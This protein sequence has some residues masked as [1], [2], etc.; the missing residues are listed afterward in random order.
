MLDDGRMLS[1]ASKMTAVRDSVAEDRRSGS[2][3]T[4][5]SRVLFVANKVAAVRDFVEQGRGESEVTD[6]GGVSMLDE[7]AVLKDFD[8]S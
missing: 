2:K 1:V 3:V 7:V 6:D 5:D 4:D 8:N